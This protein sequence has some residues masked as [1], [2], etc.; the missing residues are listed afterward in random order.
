M[1]VSA[2]ERV[3]IWTSLKLKFFPPVA[4]GIGEPPP[5]PAEWELEAGN[6]LEHI[7][8]HIEKELDLKSIDELLESL[9]T[10]KL[11]KIAVT[12]AILNPHIWKALKESWR[13]RPFSWKKWEVK[14]V[15]P[16]RPAIILVMIASMAGVLVF[17]EGETDG[18][19]FDTIGDVVW[20]LVSDLPGANE[21]R[22]KINGE[23]IGNMLG[24][25]AFNSF[26]HKEPTF[27]NKKRKWAN[28]NLGDK[29]QSLMDSPS[30]GPL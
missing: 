18:K 30:S 9:R 26:V 2:S 20:G 5:N 22:A 6:Q 27:A 19:L 21:G 12:G 16:A 15:R 8:K 14:W 1:I 29:W 7:A 23:I 11:L 4:V 24:V 17:L 3:P 28:K 10:S 25:F 13:G